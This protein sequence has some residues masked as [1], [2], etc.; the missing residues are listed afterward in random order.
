MALNQVI[1]LPNPAGTY[2]KTV[3]VELTA[4][5]AAATT[6]QAA[7]AAGFF[8]RARNFTICLTANSSVSTQFIVGILRIGNGRYDVTLLMPTS[9]TSYTQNFSS[10]DLGFDGAWLQPGDIVSFEAIVSTGAPTGIR[11]S[12]SVALEDF[13]A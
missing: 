12:V 10:A 4:V 5:G 6:I 11:I 8:V 7:I 2:S 9:A 3:G 1:Y 13:T